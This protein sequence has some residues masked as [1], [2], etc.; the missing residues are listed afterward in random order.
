MTKET[1]ASRQEPYFHKNFNSLFIFFCALV[2]FWRLVTTEIRFSALKC[3]K[4]KVQ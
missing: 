2:W 4:E 3:K 1:K